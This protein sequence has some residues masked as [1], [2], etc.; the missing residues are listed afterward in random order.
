MSFNLIKLEPSFDNFLANL[1]T[2][3]FQKIWFTKP[4]FELVIWEMDSDSNGFTFTASK[5]AGSYRN[6]KIFNNHTH[7]FLTI[8]LIK[9]ACLACWFDKH[10]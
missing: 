7:F 10:G 1:A 8:Y 2:A 4:K 5:L 3:I 6:S 9:S